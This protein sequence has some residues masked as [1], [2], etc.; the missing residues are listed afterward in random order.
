MSDTPMLEQKI[1][2]SENRVKDLEQQLNATRKH[3]ENLRSAQQIM[4]ELTTTIRSSLQNIGELLGNELSE[5]IKQE[6]IQS[7]GG[8]LNH[9]PTPATSFNSRDEAKPEQLQ[10]SASTPVAIPVAAPLQCYARSSSGMRSDG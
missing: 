2:E 6:L 9:H 3:L 8:S 10:T 1:L 5:G 7:L 4:E